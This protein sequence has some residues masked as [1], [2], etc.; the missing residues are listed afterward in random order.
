MKPR[1]PGHALQYF[2]MAGAVLALVACSG[3]LPR[4]KQV[5]PSPWRDYAE[6]QAM[7]AKIIPG[8]TRLFELKALGI[9]PEQ[10]PNVAVLGHADLLRRLI[11][12]SSFDLR[13][14]APALQ[15]CVA[16]HQACFGFEI[17][18]TNL[19]RRRSG[20]FLLDFLN[21]KRTTDV[22]GWRFDAIVVI[23]GDLVIY[24]L[25]SGTPNIRRLEE[26]RNPLGPLQGVGPSLLSR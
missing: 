20:N 1:V 10:V 3:L 24:K 7:F 4:G 17:E 11:P 21:F 15:Q 26:E 12:G 22:S 9:D 23:D 19:Q 6:A 8:N 25:W 13:S 2:C 14:L 18:Q 5:T 16:A